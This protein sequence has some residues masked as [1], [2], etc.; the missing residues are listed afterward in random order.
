MC[1]RDRLITVHE[2]TD[3]KPP[4]RSLTELKTFERGTEGSPRTWPDG[5]RFRA[6]RID[7]AEHLA[8]LEGRL[9]AEIREDVK[10]TDLTQVEGDIVVNC[11][12]LGSRELLGDP[13][14]EPRLGQLVLTTGGSLDPGRVLIDDRDIENFLY[15]IPRRDCFALGST[16]VRCDDLV[17]PDA[18]PGIRQAI[19][20]RCL[21]Y[22]S[23]AADE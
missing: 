21:L 23:D 13:C 14:F 16:F 2:A 11:T 1:I 4:D 5:W 18:D 10:V 9:D 3:G 17:S 7:P 8:W 6:P 15:V 12:G 22:T 20:Q 19:L